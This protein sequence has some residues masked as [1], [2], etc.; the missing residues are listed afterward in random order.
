MSAQMISAPSSPRV[1]AS[2]VVASVGTVLVWCL[3]GFQR[4]GA[5]ADSDLVAKEV[6]RAAAEAYAKESVRTY[7][8][9]LNAAKSAAAASAPRG[10]GTVALNIVDLGFAISD[11]SKAK[12]D[13]GKTHAGARA[14]VAIYALAG[15]PAAPAIALGLTIATLVESG[16]SASH[17]KEMLK[18]YKRV[19]EHN[20][21][22]LEIYGQAALSEAI[23]LQTFYLRA[24]AASANADSAADYVRK[25]CS[26]VAAVNSIELLDA[27]LLAMSDAL[28]FSQDFVNSSDVVF[29]WKG[30]FISGEQFLKKLPSDS[31]NALKQRR[32]ALMTALDKSKE[33]LD[34]LR[35]FY[36][37]VAVSLVTERSA[38]D[39]TRDEAIERTCL[40]TFVSLQSRVHKANLEFEAR[41][42]SRD[43][44]LMCMSQ[45]SLEFSVDALEQFPLQLCAKANDVSKVDS[46]REVIAAIPDSVESMLARTREYGEESKRSCR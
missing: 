39:L 11:F 24:I 22:T 7:L 32:V 17:Q 36:V 35:Q 6:A 45:T 46:R 30:Q 9:S 31:V 14:S 21:R 16:L 44:A 13:Q 20:A 5:N 4:T 41:R 3:S 27:C 28:W 25:N 38:T 10:A 23:S 15:G 37:D 26:D 33:T 43:R 40:K 29:T 42:G 8:D 19:A 34:V 12:T 2:R 1:S 18:I